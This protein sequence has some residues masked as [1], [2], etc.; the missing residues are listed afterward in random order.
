ME[1]VV[2]CSAFDKFV[3]VISFIAMQALNGVTRE[4]ESGYVERRRWVRALQRKM[5]VC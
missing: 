4:D 3:V 1:I 2:A 5:G